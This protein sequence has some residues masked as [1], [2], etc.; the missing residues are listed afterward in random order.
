MGALFF[1][2]YFHYIY[3][4]NE[5]IIVNALLYF[6]FFILGVRFGRNISKLEKQKD[7]EE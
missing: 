7:E 5:T 1:I 2:I 4:M 3:N 6:F